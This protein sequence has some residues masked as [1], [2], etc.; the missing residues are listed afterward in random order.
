MS[1]Q[2]IPT[3]SKKEEMQID[4]SSSK[5]KNTSETTEYP[6]KQVIAQER[7][8]LDQADAIHDDQILSD[9]EADN[10]V[11]APQGSQEIQEQAKEY[12]LFS[13]EE[14]IKE[15]KRLMESSPVQNIKP[16]VEAIRS[17]FSVKF[18]EE[19]ATKKEQFLEEGGK[20]IDFH[21][22]TTNK[23]DF[24][25]IYFNYKEKCNIYYNNL[26]KNLQ[27]N[28]KIREGL[29]DELKNLLS[30][31]EN[32]GTTYKQFKNI[33]ERWHQTGDIPRDAYNTIWNTYRH[34]VENFYDFLHLN[35]E[36][37]D[38]DFKHNLEQKLKL[39]VKTEALAAQD[40]IHAA[41]RE[42]QL[43]HKIWKEDLGPVAK[44][45]RDEVWNRF[46]AA[47]KIIHDKRLAFVREEEKQYESN[48][49]EKKQIISAINQITTNATNTHKYWQNAIKEVQALKDE[50]LKKGKVP[51]GES[52]SVW[53]LFRESTRNFNREKNTF[54]KN[55][56]NEQFS[57]L[58]K[59][60]A[61]IKIAE[62]NKES[63]DF[64]VVTP[65]MKKIQNDWKL[66]GHVPRKDSDKIWK[67]FKE[68]CNFYFN[69]VNAER[70]EESK[71]EVAN[72]EAKQVVIEE[73]SSLELNGE[74]KADLQ[75][76]KEKIT[77]WK[78]IG[79]VPFNKKDIERK[80]N[81]I[82]D[83]L[84]QKL[85]LDKK[86]A[87]M[88]RFENKLNVMVSQEDHRKLQNEEFFISKKI[89][90]V[91][92]EIN[93]LENNLGFFQHVKDDNP[94]VRDVHKSI[95]RQKEQLEIWKGKLRKIRSLR[96]Q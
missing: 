35:R 75:R 54:Y 25:S 47:T 63:D 71:I 6:D 41:F 78:N 82:L 36:F 95:A 56:K 73:V 88:I 38:L 86:E 26:K 77:A 42:L 80:F 12:N 20:E 24:N 83:G 16:F 57:N 10:T 70:D 21:Y 40:D 96:K 2:N 27:A 22:T 94:L 92:S 17:E 5:L 74:H 58:D 69:R 59:K 64:D 51:K 43:F 89:S 65:L 67:Q 8:A 66:I 68:A 28:Y 85:N 49:E 50:F 37:R 14:L 19:L 34:H 18:N 31:E 72:F 87:E 13:Q 81:T 30:V 23:K 91:Q 76:I 53:N 61:L 84:F 62:Q 52:K 44:Q 3:E 93:Q 55:Q 1:D 39:I 32:I 15:F 45:Y 90:E 11:D 7:V 46:S 4:V 9:N 29:I 60:L 33:Q 48:L 79:R